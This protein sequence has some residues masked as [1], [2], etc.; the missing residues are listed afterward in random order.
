MA[1]EDFNEHGTL[2]SCVGLA[3]LVRMTWAGVPTVVMDNHNHAFY[4][5]R[6]AIEQGRLRP[7]ATVIHVDQ[8]RDTRLPERLFDG[9]TLADAFHYTNFHLNVGNYIV[10]AHH[11]GM[12]E[13]IQFVTGATAL[14]DQTFVRRGNKILNIDLDFFAPEMADV[15]LA[16]AR[17]FIH[18]HLP[19]ASLVT[20]AT[21]PLF[22]DQ[23][24]AIA[25]LH[26]LL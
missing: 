13:E 19:S 16:V 22:I 26:A 25:V 5:W 2:Q 4:F 7:G 17:R 6:E 3:H 12:I 10:P 14:E 24:R 21:S 23:A 15:D 20:V 11:A 1:F 18:A 9:V 8:H